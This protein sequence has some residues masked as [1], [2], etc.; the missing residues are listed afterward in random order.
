[1]TRAL[2]IE[3]L[4]A[5]FPSHQMWIGVFDSLSFNPPGVKKERRIFI[6]ERKMIILVNF[7]I[8]FSF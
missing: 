6:E 2:S 7:I 1:M 4:C 3:I 8:L 5:E